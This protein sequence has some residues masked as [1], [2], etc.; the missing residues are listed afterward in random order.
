[1]RYIFHVADRWD[2][3]DDYLA[4]LLVPGDPVLEAALRRGDQAGLPPIQVSPLQGA[5][6][7]VLALAVQ[8]RRVLEIG[9]LAGYSTVWLGRA[10]GA[11]G[12]VVTL[13]VDPHHAEVARATFAEAG[14]DGVVDLRLGAALETLPAIESEG[15]G[16]F[17]LVFVD[18]DKA[19]NA[20]YLEWAVRLGRPGTLIVVDN[21]IRGGRV[22]D[23]D[24]PSADVVGSRRLHER[25]ASHGRLAAT[26]IQT[27]GSKGWTGFALALVTG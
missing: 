13:E 23:A 15:V 27:V 24:D 16:P 18:A 7:H 11:G 19:P 21:V 8:A 2:A 1:V 5:M 25:L 10:V 20:E 14:L 3:V 26:V 17:D 12:R 4:G 9:T 22:L 6:L